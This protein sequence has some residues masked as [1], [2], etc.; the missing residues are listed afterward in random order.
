MQVRSRLRVACSC[1]CACYFVF[2]PKRVRARSPD[3]TIGD[4]K[5]LIAV[6]TGTRPEKIVLKKW[7]APWWSV[8][9]CRRVDATPLARP[10]RYNV[11]K[12]H[13]TL[14]DCAFE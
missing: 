7:C 10:R 12:D 3:D 14:S 5:K 11:F 2:S 4:L 9:C 6:Q 1:A 13:I 8:S